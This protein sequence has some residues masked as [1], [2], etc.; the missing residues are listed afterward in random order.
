[1][2][3]GIERSD[4]SIEDPWGVIDEEKTLKERQERRGSQARAGK[5]EVLLH[6]VQ[7]HKVV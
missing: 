1:M 5:R 3:K 7:V 4:R 2:S 6:E